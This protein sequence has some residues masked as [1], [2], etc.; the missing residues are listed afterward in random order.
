MSNGAGPRVQA[1][2]ARF[3]PRRTTRG[4]WWLLVSRTAAPPTTV[5]TSLSV[6]S[7]VVR[8]ARLQT[9]ARHL[10]QSA[11]GRVARTASYNLALQTQ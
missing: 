5:A 3:G 4:C 11:S 1:G 9:G 8:N 2:G 10:Q 6:V 7:R